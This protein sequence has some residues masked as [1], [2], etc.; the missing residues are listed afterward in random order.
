LK[1]YRKRKR[2]AKMFCGGIANYSFI[3]NWLSGSLYF[4]AF[5][6]KNKRRN[7]RKYCG[8]LV[9]WI[10]DQQRFYY[11][12]CRYDDSS[13]VWGS[14]WYGNELK[15][16]RPTTFVDLGPRD[17]FIKEI[18][19]DPS[20]DPNCSV[21]RQI[22]PTSF[23]SFGELQGL[24]INYRLDVSN[25][26]YNLND[27]FSN[28]GFSGY[29]RPLNGDV[30]QLISINC[31]AGIEE[32]DLQNPKYLGYS[33]Q[34][35]DP[36][37]YPNVFSTAGG[38]PGVY[39]DGS[40]GK[41][42]GPLPITFDFAEDGERIRAC[43]NE[44]T[45]LDYSGN[46]VQ[47]RLT[48]SSQPVPFYLWEKI[49]RGFGDNSNSQHWDF[50]HIEVQPLQGMTYGYSLNFAPNDSTDKYLLLPMTYTFPGENFTGQTGNATNELPYDIVEVSPAPDNHFVYDNEYPGFTYLYVSSGYTVGNE[51]IAYTGTLYVR[52]G[53]AG[54]W[55][56]TPWNY[57]DDFL[58]RRTEDYYS[59]SQQ[60]LSTP[61][62]YYFGLR[63]GNTGLDKFIERFGPTG[64][65]PPAE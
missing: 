45:H 13:N 39:T 41:A 15:I 43:L 25:D 21:S 5:K 22:G 30:M 55:N 6:T 56:A 54:Q 20:L 12:S 38:I 46:T 65:F 34:I 3:N 57:N 11:K 59:G 63:P 19:T 44:P 31:E 37:F 49:A 27:F 33:Y 9:T 32:F 18:C 50:T 1:E 60:I 23:K 62:L 16:N 35:L 52:Y 7:N 14:F 17:E 36:E 8:E 24:N 42:N 61:F 26:D 4:F 47:G 10:T 29:H 2:V 58:I 40:T 28:G 64:A 53:T 51:I 48:E